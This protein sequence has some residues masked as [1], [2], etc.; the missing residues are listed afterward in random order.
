MIHPINGRN[1][2]NPV[3]PLTGSSPTSSAVQ[4]ADLGWQQKGVHDTDEKSEEKT[5]STT[6]PFSG[7]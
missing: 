3:M 1:T 6:D 2:H 5:Q 4:T 7:A